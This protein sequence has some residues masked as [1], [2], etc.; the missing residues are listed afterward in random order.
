MRERI[1]AFIVPH[2]QKGVSLGRRW[3]K[4]GMH[5]LNVHE[6]ILED[7]KIPRHN[8]LGRPGQG[9]NIA[10]SVLHEGR[11]AQSAGCLGSMKYLYKLA[12]EEAQRRQQ[13]G[14]Q[15]IEFELI[16]DK[17]AQ[18]G[19]DI[20]VAESMVY[21]VTGMINREGIDCA[22][23]AAAAKI[24]S[25]EALWSTANSAMQIAGGQ[26]YMRHF[27]YEKS[28]RDARMHLIVNGTNEV[29]RIFIALSGLK[30]PSDFL[31]GLGEIMS[32]PLKNPTNAVKGLITYT[33][34][35]LGRALPKEF[36]PVQGI[37]FLM[38]ILS[39]NDILEISPSLAASAGQLDKTIRFLANNL[40]T[41]ILK[42]GK[43]LLLKEFL[44][45]RIADIAIDLFACCAVISR[46]HS[47]ISLKGE[48]ECKAEQTIC[49]IFMAEAFQRIN[50]NLSAF[51]A[52]HDQLKNQLVK[53]LA[54]QNSYYLGL[55]KY[56]FIK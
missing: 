28:V 25:T 38:R 10:M 33:S 56:N 15:I 47:L 29:L 48:K 4:M 1:S 49:T 21:L 13:F 51:T 31:K 9:Y 6:L 36:L 16:K 34:Q 44:L 19:I 50:S 41:L 20:F 5:G 53:Y 40:E 27:P 3:D 45:K 11:L 23:E 32:S 52:N 2:D 55:T 18:M 35:R 14:K 26:G 8:M 7:V 37:S 42:Q 17:I 54:Q 22:A 24:F 39:Q 12:L 30:T 46:L 43:D